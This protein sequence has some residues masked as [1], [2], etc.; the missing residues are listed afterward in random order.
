MRLN[1]GGGK[2]GKEGYINIDIV[3][4]Y[5]D[6]GVCDLEKDK[7]PYQDGSVTE[8]WSHHCIEHLRDVHNVFNEAWRVLQPGGLFKV[9][10]PY[11]LWDGGQKPVHFQCITSSWF[12]FFR[13][14]DVY[15]LYGFHPWDIVL[16]EERLIKGSDQVYE[17]YCVLTPRK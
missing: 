6:I 17:L 2:V 1:L 9:T 4:H 16:L 3:A 15:E 5:S 8:I 7:L 14:S 11:G 12:D 13:R 10:V